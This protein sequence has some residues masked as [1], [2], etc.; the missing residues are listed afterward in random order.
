MVAKA[1]V[2]SCFM[3]VCVIGEGTGEEILEFC[4]RGNMVG[5]E[6]GWV[7]AYREELGVD[8]A[9]YSGR[10]HIIVG[11]DRENPEALENLVK[12]AKHYEEKRQGGEVGMLA[13]VTD[14]GP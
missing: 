12:R 4:N 10:R 11:L 13:E 2:G 3:Q 8:C 6:L 7:K 14:V 9:K 1:I 5:T